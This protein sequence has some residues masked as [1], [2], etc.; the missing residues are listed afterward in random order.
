MSH[1]IKKAPKGHSL[2]GKYTRCY[3][4]VN[5]NHI[6]KWKHTDAELLCAIL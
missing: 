5:Y 1:F 3:S 4:C 2:I 6:Q